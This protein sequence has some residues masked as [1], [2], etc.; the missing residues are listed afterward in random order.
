M[1]VKI[2]LSLEL[3]WTSSIGTSLVRVLKCGI[4][5]VSLV[6]AL[7]ILYAREFKGV[8]MFPEGFGKNVDIQRQ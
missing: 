3:H 2:G 8:G 7:F 1:E 6:M 4:S 5:L